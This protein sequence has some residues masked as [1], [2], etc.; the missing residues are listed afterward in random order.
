[1]AHRKA[2]GSTKN[3]RDSQPKYRGL[4]VGQG[5][6][7]KIGMILVR[8]SGTKVIA[9][10]GV[11]TGRDHTLYAVKNGVVSFREKRKIHFDN[12]TLKKKM[13]EVL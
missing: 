1:M 8:Q 5:Q 13:V 6:T 12:S 10:K 11:K 3:L 2:Q 4:K 7:V 9:G